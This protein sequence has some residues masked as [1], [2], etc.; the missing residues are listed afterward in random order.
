M[1][2]KFNGVHERKGK[3]CSSCGKSVSKYSFVTHKMYILPSGR[4]KTF[5]VGRIEEVSEKD[6]KFLLSY[7]DAKG[8]AVFEEVK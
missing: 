1:K 6:G 3:H 5:Y 2:V 7:K 4:N 8:N